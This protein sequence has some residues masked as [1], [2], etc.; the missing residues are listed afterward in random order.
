MNNINNTQNEIGKRIFLTK[1]KE[2]N[3]IKIGD[4][5]DYEIVYSSRRNDDSNENSSTE[6]IDKNLNNIKN[7]KKR[8]KKNKNQLNKSCDALKFF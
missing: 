6:I 2:N 5:L 3:N 7:I 4:N 1:L 8:N